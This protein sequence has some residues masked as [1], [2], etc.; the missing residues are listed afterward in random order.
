MH[1]PRKSKNKNLIE[2]KTPTG[3]KIV[4]NPKGNLQLNEIPKNEETIKRQWLGKEHELVIIRYSDIFNKT[5]YVL[6]EYD[7]GKATIIGKRD[8]KP[9]IESMFHREYKKL[10]GWGA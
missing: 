1:T 3:R 5:V 6:M 9:A 8:S 10:T 2:F 7:K 4:H